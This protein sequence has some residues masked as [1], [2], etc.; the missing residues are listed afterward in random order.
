MRGKRPGQTWKKEARRIRAWE[1]HQAG[2]ANVQIADALGVTAAAVGQWVKTAHDGGEAALYAKSRQGQAARLSSEQTELLLKLLERGAPSFGFVGDVWTCARIAR[3]IEQEFGVRYH[4]SHV[5]RLLHQQHWTYQTPILRAS[6][7]NEAEISVWLTQ[8][9]PLL[10]KTAE[11]ERRTMVFIDESGFYLTPTITKTWSPA[12]KTPVLHAP[13]AHEHL[14]AIGA[15]TFQGSLYMQ[16]HESSIGGHGAVLFLRHL[17]MHI[18]ER[19]L[20]LWD[21]S[22]IHRNKELDDFRR[23]DTIGRM[24]IEHFPRYAP[25]VDPQEYVW[26]QLKHVDLRNLSSY[27][28]DQLWVRLQDA[29]RRLRE[30]VGLLRKLIKHAG[31]DS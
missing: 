12:G 19:L 31:L 4:P 28:L 6:Q 11:N 2:W 25:E 17:L 18:P 26:R 23:M 29:T 13:L 16:L 1:L 10:K 5:S 8:T 15:L 14:S 21:K 30:R 24:T 20:V 27:S 7:R 9:W 3:V 22:R